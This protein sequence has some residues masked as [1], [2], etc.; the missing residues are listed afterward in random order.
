MGHG[1]LCLLRQLLHKSENV[2]DHERVEAHPRRTHRRRPRL[3][4]TV[5][6]GMEQS[7]TDHV[8]LQQTKERK[9][10]ELH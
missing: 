5:L 3:T 7:F 1:V 4:N 10:Y 9:R 2:L 8:V 6:Q